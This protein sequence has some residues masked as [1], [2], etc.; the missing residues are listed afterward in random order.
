MN[1]N[2][3]AA[4]LLAGRVLLGL[5]FLVS[6]LGK[7]GRFAG[8]A[9]FM[10]SK[11]LPAADVLLV[12]TIVLEL[13]GGL[14]LMAGWQTRVAAWAL[15][16]FTAVAALVFHAF[17]AAEAPAFQNQLNHFLKN[18]AV[19]GG[20]LCVAAAGAGAFSIDGRGERAAGM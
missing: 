8:V 5:L 16:A 20:L 15:L 18:A 4:Q 2:K 7:I 19:M 10:A 17:W 9:G 1:A 13:A 12:A 3:F 14:A 11:G 6:G